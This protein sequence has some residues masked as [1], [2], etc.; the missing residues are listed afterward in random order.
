[1]DILVLMDL[2]LAKDLLQVIQVK[3][4]M[5]LNLYR[6]A[7]LRRQDLTLVILVDIP[8]YLM[9]T[10]LDLKTNPMAFSNLNLKL[11]DH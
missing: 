1:V 7:T 11:L 4:P 9:D 3:D 8:L 5:V 10:I 2:N 6:V